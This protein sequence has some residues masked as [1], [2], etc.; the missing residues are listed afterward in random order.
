M[1]AKPHQSKVL[2]KGV[3]QI[4]ATGKVKNLS[5]PRGPW[6][7]PSWGSRGEAG[8][9]SR[10]FFSE[11]GKNGHPAATKNMGFGIHAVKTADGGGHLENPSRKKLILAVVIEHF[12]LLQVRVD[13]SG[14]QARLA[15]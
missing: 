10:R 12:S 1:Q 5:L 3:L 13:V 2:P 4:C 14:V 6:R 11:N 15:R 9:S 7:L 8:P